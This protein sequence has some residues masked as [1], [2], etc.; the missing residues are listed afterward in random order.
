[1]VEAWGMGIPT[2][3]TDNFGM[4]ELVNKFLQRYSEKVLFPLGDSEALFLRLEELLSNKDLYDEFSKQAWYVV[5][6]QLN[7]YNFSKRLN[8]IIAEVSH[9]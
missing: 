4:K 6:T 9:D 7:N 1:M 8:Q 3:A 2:I 5:N